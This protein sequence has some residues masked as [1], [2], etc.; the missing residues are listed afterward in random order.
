MLIILYGVY[1]GL[2]PLRVF[3][4]KRST[5]GAFAVPFRVLNQKNMTE[6][7]VLFKNWYLLVVKKK[8]QARPTDSL[9]K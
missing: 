2:L 8:F 4:I 7:N 6:D 9:A 1:S 5:A 3:S